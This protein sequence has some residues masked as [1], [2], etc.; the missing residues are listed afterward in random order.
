M[1]PTSLIER[2]IKHIEETIRSIYIRHA[3]DDEEAEEFAAYVKYRLVE[4]DYKIIRKF[5]GISHIKTYLYT[6]INRIFLDEKRKQKGRWRPSKKA[7]NIGEPA[8]K[9]EELI[10]KYNHTFD[11]AYEVLKTNYKLTL[12]K[13][14]AYEMALKLKRKR[15]KDIKIE[16][17]ESLINIPSKGLRPDEALHKK[18]LIEIQ[19][20]IET[21]VDAMRQ[22][23][24]AEE[25]LILKMRFGDNFKVS[26]IAKVLMRNRNDIDKSIK[27][28]LRE[29]KEGILRKGINI[30]DVMDV[31]R[32][33][34]NDGEEQNI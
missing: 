18:K 13:N 10:Y 28:I 16:A 17:E 34:E 3:M 29:F 5:K 19:G 15:A 25:R 30:N 1:N 7:Q 23:L 33:I 12:D 21:T 26:E 11:E 24:S 8:V 6:V 20:Q 22:K 27:S 31:I 14:E 9:L 2:N 4:D 32:F